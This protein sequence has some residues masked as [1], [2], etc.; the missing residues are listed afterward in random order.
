MRCNVLWEPIMMHSPASQPQPYHRIEQRIEIPG[1][2]LY[3]QKE[4]VLPTFGYSPGTLLN[5]NRG[6]IAIRCKWPALLP[7]Q[8]IKMRLIHDGTTY[9]IRGVVAYRAAAG[10]E[11]QYGVV[12]IDVPIEFDQLINRHLA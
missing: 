2:A 3:L 12:F 10:E 11:T 9:N 4:R 7:L 6:G 1:A 8:K 5:L